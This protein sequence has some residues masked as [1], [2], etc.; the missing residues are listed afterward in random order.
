[1]CNNAKCASQLEFQ[2]LMT[3]V[4]THMHIWHCLH[5]QMALTHRSSIKRLSLRSTCTNGIVN[6]HKWQWVMCVGPSVMEISTIG[7]LNMH[8]WHWHPRPQKKRQRSKCT[9]VFD[10]EMGP[11]IICIITMPK[12]WDLRETICYT[13]LHIW[14]CSQ[15]QKCETC[16][17]PFVILSWH[18]GP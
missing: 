1:M 13:R 8:K 3:R 2:R 6:M 12:V 10:K 4:Y 16:G 11:G 14:H 18:T 17:R 15:C 7:I 9:P 5:A